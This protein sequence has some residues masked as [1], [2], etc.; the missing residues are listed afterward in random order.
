[1]KRHFY[2]KNIQTY[3]KD[4]RIIQITPIYPYLDS[5]VVIMLLRFISP[6]H[7]HT[8]TQSLFLQNHVS[9]CCHD[10]NC[11]KNI[12]LCMKI[13]SCMNSLALFFW[14]LDKC[15]NVNSV[16]GCLWQRMISNW[17]AACILDSKPYLKFP[18]VCS[19]LWL[20]H[21]FQGPW[22]HC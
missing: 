3:R 9:T 4:S 20:A 8:H 7:R 17:Y 21:P 10:L 19:L 15:W 11:S 1:M 13:W 16:T 22:N 5:S 6:E 18:W 2:L 14:L 12:S